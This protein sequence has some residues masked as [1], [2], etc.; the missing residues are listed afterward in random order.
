MIL[1][2]LAQLVRKVAHQRLQVLLDHKVFRVFRAK[3]ARSDLQALQAHKATVLQAQQ[4]RLVRK[5]TQ[6]QGQLVRQV[7]QDLRVLIPQ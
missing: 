4:D 7:R 2:Q 3:L 6:S 1:A 5:A